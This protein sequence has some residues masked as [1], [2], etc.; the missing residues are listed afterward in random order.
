MATALLILSGCSAEQEGE[1]RRLAL[2]VPSTKEAPYVYDLWMWTWLVV[3]IV[4]VI[5]WGL[6]FYASLR[7]RRRSESEIPVQTRYNL[8]IEI[9]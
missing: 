2:P 5:V 1:I 9:F 7:Y 3:M 8:P 6:I 4:G